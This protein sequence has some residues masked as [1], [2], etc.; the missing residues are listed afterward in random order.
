M[1]ELAE[2][3]LYVIAE[4]GINHNGSVDEA[5]WLMREAANAGV[6]AVKFQKRELSEIY[7]KSLLDD[8]NSAEWSFQYLIPQLQELELDAD[9]YRLLRQEARNLSLDFIVTPFDPVS[10]D[11]VATLDLDAVKFSSADLTNWPLIS[12]VLKRIKCPAIFSTGMWDDAT[13][14]RSAAFIEEIIDRRW[15]MLLCQSTYPAPPESLNLLY[16]KTLHSIAPMIGYSGHE[17]GVQASVMAHTL[18]ATII[19]K[20]ISR[21][22]HQLGPDHKASLTPEQFFDLV[23]Q[24]R[25]AR[26]MLGEDK[27]AITMA[28]V[29]N[30]EVFAKSIVSKRD[31]EAGEALALDDIKFM[32]PGKGITPDR[33][34][35]FLGKPLS[36]PKHA[37]EYI[38]EQDFE[39]A[40]RIEDWPKF[41]FSRE[42]GVKCRFHD[43]DDYKVLQ[44]PVIE[45][46]CSDRDITEKMTASNPQSSLVLHAPEIIGKDLFDLCSDDPEILRKSSDIL[47]KTLVRAR[48]LAPGFR[49]DV[50]PKIV[51]HVGGMSLLDGKYNCSEVTHKAERFLRDIDL[52]GVEL[53]PENLPPRPW[54]L[55]GQWHQFGYMRPEDM[56]SFCKSLGLGMTFDICHAQLYCNYAG[57]SLVDYLKIVQPYVRHVHISDAS[58]IDGEGVQVGEGDLDFDALFRGFEKMDITWVPEIWSGHVN[59]GAGTFCALCKLEKYG[60]TGL[61]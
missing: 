22:I 49:Q 26:T 5:L 25:M 28:E 44:T 53:L 10:A 39:T 8:P 60:Q 23:Q 27:K 30:R 45:F 15:A 12:H 9:A 58:G 46:H 56:A 36:R 24:L 3:G 61:L 42:W 18:G 29:L 4:I 31:L 43:F 37:G 14:R 54:Y 41:E 17:L 38:S 57:I 34:Q 19:E 55:G 35:D 40:R 21:D 32:S 1:H 51:L 6:D 59:H 47:E 11:F 33:L 48:E 7:V 50:K 13:I 2:N 20:H 16:L 52:E